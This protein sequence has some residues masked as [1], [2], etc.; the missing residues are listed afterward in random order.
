MRGE[1]PNPREG[2]QKHAVRVAKTI[3]L[4]LV[5]EKN[6]HYNSNGRIGS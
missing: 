5:H 4:Y 2:P 3:L 6:M 1:L